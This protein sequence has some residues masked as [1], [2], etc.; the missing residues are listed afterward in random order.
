M[1]LT[2]IRLTRKL[3][4]NLNY[5]TGKL[6]QCSFNLNIN[7]FALHLINYSRVKFTSVPAKACS[8]KNFLCNSCLL[9]FF[10]G[11]NWDEHSALGLV[12]SEWFDE[13]NGQ[14]KTANLQASVHGG[15]DQQRVSGASVPCHSKQTDISQSTVCTPCL[16][17]DVNHLIHTF[18]PVLCCFQVL[19]LGC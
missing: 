18:F 2:W 17:V 10:S 7:A 3:T 1:N 5:F 15:R 19:V 8:C 11:G 16:S 6:K 14:Q 9:F 13:P 4:I 12:M